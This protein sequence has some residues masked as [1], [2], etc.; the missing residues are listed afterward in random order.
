[1]PFLTMHRLRKLSTKFRRCRVKTKCQVEE[2]LSEAWVSEVSTSLRPCSS[3]RNN[4]YRDR[5][6]KTARSLTGLTSTY[7]RRTGDDSSCASEAIVR[8]RRRKNNRTLPQFVSGSRLP[9]PAEE[10]EV[11]KGNRVREKW[12]GLTSTLESGEEC[13]ISTTL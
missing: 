12:S 3:N 4:R 1:M 13:T 11:T 6:T 2:L 8:N 7:L 9:E 5:E 10:T